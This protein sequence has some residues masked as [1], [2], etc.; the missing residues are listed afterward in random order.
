MLNNN[1]HLKDEEGVIYSCLLRGYDVIQTCSFVLP[2]EDE[3]DVVPV[4]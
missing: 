2:F 1:Q 3:N 4:Q